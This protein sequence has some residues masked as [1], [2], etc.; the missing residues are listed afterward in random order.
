LAQR[1]GDGVRY[2]RAVEVRLREGEA[3]IMLGVALRLT[4]GDQ[5]G[6]TCCCGGEMVLRR[7]S[8]NWQFVEWRNVL[9]A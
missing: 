9:C 3:A 5:R 7:V 1:K 6:L 4:P 2:V 8:A